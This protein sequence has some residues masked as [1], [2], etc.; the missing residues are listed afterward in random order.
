MKKFSLLLLLW[1][2]TVRAQTPFSVDSAASFLRTISADIGPRTMGSPNERRAMEFGLQKFREFGLTEVSLMEMQKMDPDQSGQHWNVRSG[3]VVGVLRGRT[4]RIILIGGHI[5]S[6]GPEIP[7]TNDDGSG[8]ATVLELARILSKR[9]NESTIVFCLFGGEERGMRGSQFFVDQY[10]QLG[11]VALMLQIDMANGGDMLVPLVDAQEHSA[12]EWLVSAA[13]QEFNSL[14]YTGLLFP[15]HFLTLSNTFPGGAVGSDHEP[16]LTRGIPAIDFTSS[17]N[18]PIHTPQD[19]F[20]NF[21][22]SGLK[23]TGDLVYKLVERF[24]AGVPAERDG[25]YFLFQVRST[26]LFVPLW[27]LWIFVVLAV[28]L[29]VAGVV[30]LRRRRTEISAP[31]PSVPGLKLFLLML[32]IQSFVWISVDIPGLLMGWRFPWLVDATGYFVLAFFAGLTGIWCSLRLAQRM[33][34][35]VDPYRYFLTTTA[36][37][38]AF[39]VLFSLSSIK[40]AVYPSTALFFLGLAV[41]VENPYIKYF[42]WAVSPHFMF[43]LIFSE[44]FGLLS[45]GITEVPSTGVVGSFFLNLIVILFFSIWSFPFL[46]GFATVYVGSQHWLRYF[47]K[48]SVL[49]ICGV[50]FVLTTVFL[51]FQ[52]PFSREWQ[53]AIHVDQVYNQST[54][55]G[56]VTV[57]SNEYFHGVRVRTMDSDTTLSGWSREVKLKDLGPQP[58]WVT[59]ERSIMTAQADS[60]VRYTLLVTLNLKHRPYEL[61]VTYSTPK[62]TLSSGWSHLAWSATSHALG[63]QWYSFPDTSLVIPV[64]FVVTGTD[65]ITELV[66][67]TFV[68]P[69]TPVKLEREFVNPVYRSVV[70]SSAV[71]PGAR[72]SGPS[73]TLRTEP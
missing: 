58:P 35:S 22:V 38:L 14:G 23:R 43:R 45:R 26:P 41:L 47:K 27:S 46:T 11:R 8:S 51:V 13:Y 16:F 42:F 17:M 5:D 31:R 4:D 34:L 44:G 67:A 69:L 72:N 71:L 9:K 1:N 21:K 39:I 53:Q 28:G 2:L 57:R 48:K 37:L 36:F 50:C 55:K 40:L 60:G 64:S 56:T 24:D 10:P 15:T 49:A 52:P 61:H 32:V 59:I 12:P 70:R 66:E 33:R 68:E 25:R 54:Q 18:D 7:G 73:L 63:M 62:G 6:A 30:V 20:E 3:V 19:N 65:S 29:G